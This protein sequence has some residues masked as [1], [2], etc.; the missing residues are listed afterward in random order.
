MGVDSDTKT[1]Q[2]LRPYALL[3]TYDVRI[4][5]SLVDD[6]KRYPMKKELGWKVNEIARMP[7]NQSRVTA[8]KHIRL[9]EERNFLVPLL[10]ERPPIGYPV[11]LKLNH[12]QFLNKAE[13]EYIKSLIDFMVLMRK[14]NKLETL[15]LQNYVKQI[16]I[17]FE[18]M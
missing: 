4:L 15:D 2:Y 8:Q 3:S 14:D 9:L 18:D 6:E 12:S 5:A 1:R 10:P 11:Y 17:V 7:I 13:S 16:T